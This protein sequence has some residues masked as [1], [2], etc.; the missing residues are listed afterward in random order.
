LEV[1]HDE[2]KL[3][4]LTV[5]AF[6]TLH[7][8]A[9]PVGYSF[10]GANSKCTLATDLGF[11]TSSVQSA[12]DGSDVLVLE[13]NHDPAMLKRGSYPWPLKQRILSNRGH[14]ANEE[15][16]WALVHMK[17]RPKKL[18]LAHLSEENNRPELAKETVERVLRE[19]GAA[20]P[21]MEITVARQNDMDFW[22]E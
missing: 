5:K 9:D 13:T 20:S 11:I 12:I 7:D 2:M 10:Y 6:S 14:L 1:I 19:Q 17:K 15:A 18:F 16:A 8:A 4:P 22:C 21:T 3:G